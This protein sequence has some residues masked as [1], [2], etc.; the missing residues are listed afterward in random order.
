MAIPR[1]GTEYNF[2]LYWQQT[3]AGLR[4]AKDYVESL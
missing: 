2:Y 4:E 3:G 1:R